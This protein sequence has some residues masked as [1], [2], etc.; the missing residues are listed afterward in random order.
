VVGDGLDIHHVVQ[1]N[2][3]SQIIPG[4]NYST[5]A[6]IAHPQAEHQAIP[7]VVGTYTGSARDL[8]ANDIRNLRAFTNAPNSS[9]QSLID[10]NKIL[11][12]G[13]FGR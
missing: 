2:P 1:G 6:G 9:L 8:L 10:L 7:N 4:Y 5:A 3:G 13:I 11:Y 12:P